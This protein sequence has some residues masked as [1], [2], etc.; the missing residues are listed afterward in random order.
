VHSGE[1]RVLMSLNWLCYPN[2]ES[3]AHSFQ[4]D[5]ALET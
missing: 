2:L 3:Y 5:I 4:R 1:R